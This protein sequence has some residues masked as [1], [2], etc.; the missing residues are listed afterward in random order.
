MHII[1]GDNIIINNICAIVFNVAN[2]STNN[3]N[4]VAIKFMMLKTTIKTCDVLSFLIFLNSMFKSTIFSFIS[5]NLI[6]CLLIEVILYV[7]FLK[8]E[9]YTLKSGWIS[10]VVISIE[11]SD[12]R[13]KITSLADSITSHSFSKLI[14][15]VN[16]VYI[17]L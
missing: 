14:A 6:L 9:S 12:V 15:L 11:L 16:F 4:G 7:Q 13:L 8:T 10:D 5:S 2:S 17:V 3:L 1:I